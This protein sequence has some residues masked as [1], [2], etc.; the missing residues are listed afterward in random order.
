MLVRDF[1]RLLPWALPL[2]ILVVVFIKYSDNDSLLSLSFQDHLE[3][4][5]RTSNGGGRVMKTLPNNQ[6]A[7]TPYDGTK[8]WVFDEIYSVS[9]KDRKY[10]L[11]S[12][13]EYE[14]I[15]PNII[16]HPQM[17]DTW[18]I[19]AMQQHSDVPN[20]VWFAEL[21]CNAQFKKGALQ[22][23][24]GAQILPIAATFAPVEPKC[25]G[26]L[27]YFN[28]NIGPH[29]GRVFYGPRNPYTI[30]GSLSENSCFGQWIMDFRMLMDWGF[31]KPVV[32]EN[33]KKPTDLQRPGPVGLI[34]KNW[35][36]F[37]GFDEGIYIHYD[38]YPKRSFAKMDWKYDGTV[39]EDLAPVTAASDEKCIA[40]FFPKVAPEL[41]SIHQA[42][43]S[44]SIT[45]CTRAQNCE[46]N[47]SNTFLFTVFQHKSYHQYHSVYTPYVMA[48]Q[49]APPFAMHAVSKKPFWIHGRGG[50]GK[51]KMPNLNPEDSRNWNQTEMFYATSLSWKQQHMK[52]HGYLDD[53]LFIAF[54][55]EDERTGGIDV[56]ASDLL[57]NLGLC[58]EP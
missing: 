35:F 7:I 52:Y 6:V 28:M 13:G 5:Y 54:G 57:G 45:M 56:R 46:I 4:T 38:I 40:K 12:F 23:I 1:R 31:E 49:Q 44:L 47:E 26:N 17:N 11:I 53:V 24:K 25:T 50:P 10:F 19:V 18:V 30:Y 32:R 33:F 37:W 42:T 3:N 9:T 51:G 48:F 34:E 36:I 22:C 20:S 58:S 29:D 27:K 8:D 39:G 14:A 2:F 43:N 15:N 16:P 55:I 21:V 41:E